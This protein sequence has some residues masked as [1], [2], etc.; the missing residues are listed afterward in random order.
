MKGLNNLNNEERRLLN[1]F[2]NSN[3][4]LSLQNI[5]SYFDISRRTF[6]NR[7]K[8]I[9]LLLAQNGLPVI[10]NKR[11]AGYF[12]KK[13]PILAK[14]TQKIS[15][16]YASLRKDD[17]LNLII[18]E[19]LLGKVSINY[20]TNKYH[21]SRTTI[22]SD[23]KIIANKYPKLKIIS[24]SAGHKIGAAEND[25]RKFML[26]Q[27]FTNAPVFLNQ[28][29]E[30]KVEMK[31][32][33]LFYL[34]KIGVKFSENGYLVFG[35]YLKFAIWRYQNGMR[36][37]KTIDT[38]EH[39]EKITTNVYRYCKKLLI[40]NGVSSKTEVIALCEVLFMTQSVAIEY[41]KPDFKTKIIH[42]AHQIINTYN[43]MSSSNSADDNFTEALAT[44][45]C[46]TYFRTLY[47]QPFVSKSLL[48]IPKK[49]PATVTFLKSACQPLE[50]FI[51]KP[52]PETELD[53][54]ST[55]FISKL[56]PIDNGSYTLDD[57]TGYNE[58]LHSDILLVCS[59]GV[60]T[61]AMVYSELKQIY[62]TVKFSHSLRARD[63]EKILSESKTIKG[64]ITT[65]PEIK[66][67]S[68]PFIKVSPI[69]TNKDKIKIT[70]LF[71]NVFRNSRSQ[72]TSLVESILKIVSQYTEIKDKESLRQELSNYIF[73][74]ETEK[75]VSKSK[76]ILT[77]LLKSHIFI[78][79][80]NKDWKKLI[81]K[82]AN[83]L[84]EDKDIT[85][86][87]IQAIF[88]LIKKFGPYMVLGTEAFL[89]HAAPLDG[90]IKVGLAVTICKEPIVI[91]AHGKSCTVK[92]IFVMSPGFHH[93][94]DK[95][96]NQLIS[97][98]NDK[99]SMAKFLNA[100]TSQ[101]ARNVLLE[102]FS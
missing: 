78:N 65:S 20:L 96:L 100:K 44:H 53:L 68:V 42:I 67:L 15:G 6:F 12:I 17:R 33:L 48:N 32:D 101:E 24:T 11:G 79:S 7:I 38:K 5:L 80:K 89:A 99:G 93:E 82:T 13:T 51:K 14:A 86:K 64:V 63:V 85:E 95:M 92:C 30:L 27:L 41:I 45:L 36:L 37:E 39:I 49:Y 35:D 40:K 75:Q 25:V 34:R 52:L 84:L 88:H 62:P 8:K 2:I 71:A 47:D 66:K 46:A 19:M 23:F 55:Y 72:V 59:S 74:M 81:K 4:P 50:N 77:A 18:W 28:I 60:G 31:N 21:V 10:L 3:I 16:K 94:Q 61:S 70:K 69:L 58:A 22:I 54:I 57:L 90:A 87:Y 29:S 76:N 43:R 102:K 56:G 9:N 97:L 83:C 1:Y 98:I 26:H 91:K 73:A